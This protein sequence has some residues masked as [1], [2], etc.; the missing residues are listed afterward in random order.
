MATFRTAGVAVKPM[1][2]SDCQKVLVAVTYTVTHR[3]TVM[4]V[5]ASN[6]LADHWS[7]TSGIPAGRRIPEKAPQIREF[8]LESSILALN[9]GGLS[10]LS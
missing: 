8:K 4:S 5:A 2:R 10:T 1:K 3:P 9:R 7:T 6:S